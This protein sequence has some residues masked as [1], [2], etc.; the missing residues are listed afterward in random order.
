MNHYKNLN[1]S[2]LLK[3]YPDEKERKFN[4]QE[5]HKILSNEFPDFLKEY[6]HTPAMQRLSGIGLLCGT[7]WTPL[8]KNRFY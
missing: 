3:K 5:Y 6:I 1:W 7:D 4:I 8:Y 2:M